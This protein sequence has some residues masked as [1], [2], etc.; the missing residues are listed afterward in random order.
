MLENVTNPNNEILEFIFWTLTRHNQRKTR[1]P[2]V[3]EISEYWEIFFEKFGRDKCQRNPGD[4]SNKNWN[5]EYEINIERKREIG[6]LYFQLKELDHYFHF[7]L[8]GSLPP[9]NPQP[10]SAPT[11][12]H[13]PHPTLGPIILARPPHLIPIPTPAS[14][15]HPRERLMQ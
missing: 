10:L 15:P 7:Q 1:T 2:I 8:T 13:T 6:I 5:L 3:F 12:L 4:L 14:A 9:T 11:S